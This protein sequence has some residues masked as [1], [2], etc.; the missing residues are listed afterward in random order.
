MAVKTDTDKYIDDYYSPD[1]LHGVIVRSR[2]KK[3]KIQSIGFPGEISG[4]PAILTSEDIPGNKFIS[5]S[6]D[7]MPLLCTGEIAYEGEPVLLVADKTLKSAKEAAADIEIVCDKEP[8]FSFSPQTSREIIEERTT[9]RKNLSKGNAVKALSASSHIFEG[10][11]ATSTQLP[12]YSDP[13]G[14]FVKPGKKAITVISSSQW[15]FHV[16]SSVASALNIPEENV[17]VKVPALS[18]H[19]DGKIWYPSLIAVYTALLA[20][21]TQKPVRMILP[22]EED[23][24]YGPRR[25]PVFINHKTGID[26]TG[27][28]TGMDIEV[29]IDA[30]AYPV[31]SAEMLYRACHSVTGFY[32]CPNISINSRIIRTNNP[33]AGPLTGFG[34]NQSF[35]SVEMHINRIAE[36]SRID[37]LTWRKNHLGNSFEKKISKRIQSQIKTAEQVLDD[38]G[39]RSDFLRKYSSY[40]LMKKRKNGVE[41]L[42]TSLRGIGIAL[43]YQI[44]GFLVQNESQS[45][46]SVTAR[47]DD[48]EKLHISTSGI[49]GSKGTR[50]IWRETAGRI[51][52][53]ETA[54]IFI[55]DIDTS[56]VPDSGPSILSHNI[57]IISRLI[58]RSC[59]AIQQQRFRNPLPILVKRSMKSPKADQDGDFSLF[60]SGHSVSWGAAVVEV[61]INPI[62]LET[63]IRSIWLSVDCGQILNNYLAASTLEAGVLHALEWLKFNSYQ[64]D[65]DF[66]LVGLTGLPGPADIPEIQIHFM[67]SGKRTQP[68][69]IGELPC[70]LIPA[71]FSTALSQATG[72]YIDSIP[73]TPDRIFGYQEG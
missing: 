50:H 33:P 39:Q 18:P 47:L 42:G 20:W 10:R 41:K 4:N 13:Q 8:A 53:I 56:I 2:I 65:K 62:T 28:I 14:A 36:L 12:K 7:S 66:R 1:M 43:A 70:S 68:S 73:V 45:A 61:E 49:P 23:I 52:G 57:S 26:K 30:G 34:F 3:G 63:A 24:Q 29:L 54:N 60:R 22:P 59:N 31:L 71:A 55:D 19:L 44:S 27:K 17:I 35:F 40:E 38:A 32:S 5:F 72:Y 25:A 37:P 64:K 21:K 9:A 58:E 11:Y 67:E 6:S 15:P 69:G 48:N 16:R 46:Y 51:L